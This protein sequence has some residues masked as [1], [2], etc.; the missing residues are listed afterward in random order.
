M[1]IVIHLTE[2]YHPLGK[3][4]NIEEDRGLITIFIPVLHDMTDVIK[5]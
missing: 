2:A 1:Y 3:N 5:I 4:K